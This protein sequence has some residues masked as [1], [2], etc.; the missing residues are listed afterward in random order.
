[1]SLSALRH[2]H[3]VHST[4]ECKHYIQQELASKPFKSDS[5]NVKKPFSVDINTTEK[6]IRSTTAPCTDVTW[7]NSCSHL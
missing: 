3:L 7:Y 6:G 2:K 5:L 4:Y 1:M